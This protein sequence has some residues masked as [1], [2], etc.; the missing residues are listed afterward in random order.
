M[1]LD[2]V[3]I[4]SNCQYSRKRQHV[5][6]ILLTMSNNSERRDAPLGLRITPTLK[7]AL[8]HAARDDHRSVSSMAERI[9]TEWLESKGY[10][11]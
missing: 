2:L 8:E 1:L 7:K 5:N 11:T 10:L 9:I 3:M 6:R 4:V